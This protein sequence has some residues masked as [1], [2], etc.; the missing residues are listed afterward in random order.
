MFSRNSN[1]WQHLPIRTSKIHF[2]D[3]NVVKQNTVLAVQL[4]LSQLGLQS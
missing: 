1:F 3:H 2:V 4:K